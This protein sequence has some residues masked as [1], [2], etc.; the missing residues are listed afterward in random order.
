MDIER[1]SVRFQPVAQSAQGSA[2]TPREWEALARTLGTLE[3][4]GIEFRTNGLPFVR[5]T[6]E[7]DKSPAFSIAHRTEMFAR[8][9]AGQVEAALANGGLYHPEWFILVSL[10]LK[11][12]LP[13]TNEEKFAKD[14]MWLIW[15][16]LIPAE[17]RA[18]A[19]ART[20]PPEH[21]VRLA[22]VDEHKPT[23]SEQHEK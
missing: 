4:E 15:V 12:L 17:S 2:L 10:D 22:V 20:A 8:I 16:R 3:A 14:V 13:L 5:G 18:A 21:R 6:S 1:V 7:H 23:L 9:I 19:K 11:T